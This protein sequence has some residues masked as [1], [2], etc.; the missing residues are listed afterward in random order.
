[1]WPLGTAPR[2]STLRLQACLAPVPVFFLLSSEWPS[3]CAC[4]QYPS[5]RCPRTPPHP[6]AS[7]D[8]QHC[9]GNHEGDLHL[10]RP[11]IPDPLVA[12]SLPSPH[13]PVAPGGVE[14]TGWAQYQPVCVCLFSPGLKRLEISSISAKSH[15]ICLQRTLI[16]IH[17]TRTV[18]YF[19]K[20]AVNCYWAPPYSPYP[21]FGAFLSPNSLLFGALQGPRICLWAAITGFN[22]ANPWHRDCWFHFHTCDKQLVCLFPSKPSFWGPLGPQSSCFWRPAGPKYLSLLF[23]G[24]QS[25]FHLL[26]SMAQG[27]WVPFSKG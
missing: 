24:A 25:R 13:S 19:P 8:D 21:V 27:P 6:R 18:P 1:M 3:S 17:G 9:T 7:N 2:P 15:R 4:L 14:A 26:S 10:A 22:L 20:D 11:L 23:L 16:R 5:A 12:Q